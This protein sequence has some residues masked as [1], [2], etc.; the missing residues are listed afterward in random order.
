MQQSRWRP[1][2]CVG[3]AYF[4]VAVFV[5][6]LLT[7]ARK[8]P[9]RW[10]IAGTLWSI[11]AGSLGCLG[12]LGIIVAFNLG[13]SPFYVMP[14][15]FGCAPVVNTLVTLLLTRTARPNVLFLLGIAMVGLGAAG[16]LYYK[17]VVR[18]DAASLHRRGPETAVSFA[19]AEV[20]GSKATP[21]KSQ[22]PVATI[23]AIAATAL[24]WG[25]YGP[26][27]HKGQLRMDGSRLRP[28]IC[29]GIA[30][31]F[32]AILIPLFIISSIG[33]P[34]DWSVRGCIWSTLAGALG[35][36]GALGVILAFN[37]GGS[38]VF[39]MPIVFGGAPVINTLVTTYWAY[40]RSGSVGEIRT[41]FLFSLGLVI[42]GAVT[43]LVFAP[44]GKPKTTV[45]PVT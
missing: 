24:C 42:A 19:R 11:V 8:E 12:S 17:P 44:R 9:G 1:F 2:V 39:V 13:G 15:V 16:V 38:P 18:V 5:P 33:D 28:F 23:L 21:P 37:S 36:L 34:G 6:S 4:L 45:P 40:L 29:V 10:T 14:L 25:S 30:Y 3:V 32:L 20:G 35:A 7:R 26:T 41:E 31:F 22:H 43:V 27:L